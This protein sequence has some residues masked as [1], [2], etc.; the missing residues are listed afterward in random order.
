MSIK[1]TFKWVI[2]GVVVITIGLSIGAISY[3]YTKVSEFDKVFAEGVLVNQTNIGG[4]TRDEAT[5]KIQDNLEQQVKDKKLIV[6]KSDISYEIALGELESEYNIGEILDQAYAVGH[7]GNLFEKYQYMQSTPQNTIP[8]EL[9][10]LYDKEKIH[11][12]LEASSSKFRIEPVDANI[13]RKN[14]QFIITPEIEGQQLDLAATVEK[15]FNALDDDLVQDIEIEA[16]THKIPAKYIAESFKDI[17]NIVASFTTSYN[18]ADANRN[19]NLKV[20][21][22]KIN[23]KLMPGEV[24]SLAKQLEPFSFD[25]GYRNS[26]VIVNGKLEDG[27]GG[28][29]C[30]IASTL[31][32]SLLLTELEITMRQNHSLSVAYVP[33]GRDATYATN[34]IDFKFKNNTEYPMFIESY[35]ESNKVY[36][37]I[38]AHSSIKSEYDIKFD[39]VT[40]EVIKAPAP[41][42]IKDPELLIGKEVQELKPLTGKKVKL[43]KLYYKAGALIKK[44]LVNNSYYRPRGAIIRVGTKAADVP[45]FNPEVPNTF[46]LPSEPEVIWPPVESEILIP[47]ES[48]VEDPI[49]GE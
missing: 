22:N 5:K 15:A 25:E 33:P 31:Y 49:L 38:F 36:V 34:A 1:H 21:A 13:T 37:N 11:S 41:K 18:N 17:Q 45:V 46:E 16:I 7:Q 14:K 8:F 43:Y 48:I 23:T 29:V 24:F 20:A 27:I 39:S 28:G 35:C 30:Q 42:Y 10:Y 4:L 12:L 32:N 44:D 2:L 19:T 6:F 26:K 40:T 9:K 47:D 3:I